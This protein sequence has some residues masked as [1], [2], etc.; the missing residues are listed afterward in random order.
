MR[1]KQYLE[2]SAVEKKEMKEK[3]IQEK[4]KRVSDII[5]NYLDETSQTGSFA[6]IRWTRDNLNPESISSGETYKGGNAIL[7]TQR[8]ISEN[9][10]DNR[11]I[12]H[13]KLS[14]I[15][16]ERQKEEKDKI[17]VKEK[18]EFTTPIKFVSITYTEDY[19]KELLKNEKLAPEQREKYTK[20][21]DTI[22]ER[23]K[24]TGIKPYF[25]NIGY[26]S[27][28]NLSQLNP[29]ILEYF[30]EKK[31]DTNLQMGTEAY[32]NYLIKA[33]KET[34]HVPVVE[35]KLSDETAFRGNKIT[36][37]PQENFVND[38]YYLAT[39]AHEISHS[40]KNE[41]EKENTKNNFKLDNI[42]NYAVEEMKAE[43]SAGITLV[44][45]GINI[46]S[47]DSEKNIF[48]S[49]KGYIQHYAKSIKSHEKL[50]D[51]F[52][53]VAGSALERSDKILERVKEYEKT[54]SFEDFKKDYNYDDEIELLNQ[55]FGEKELEKH[56]DK[57]LH[58]YSLDTI[59]R[60]IDDSLSKVNF[61]FQIEDVDM[62]N[63][64]HIDEVT[65]STADVNNE[66]IQ[67]TEFPTLNEDT[68][69]LE[70][71]KDKIDVE[72]KIYMALSDNSMRKLNATFKA[73]TEMLNKSEAIITVPKED[74]DDYKFKKMEFE[75]RELDFK[76]IDYN[77]EDF[78]NKTN[79][80][81]LEKYKNTF[82]DKLVV[83]AQMTIT[84]NKTLSTAEKE[85]DFLG[86]MVNEPY[87][88]IAFEYSPNELMI[89]KITA[90]LGN[91]IRETQEYENR[92]EYNDEIKLEVSD[93]IFEKKTLLKILEK[94]DNIINHYM[95]DDN[96]NFK[97]PS[98]M[99]EKN[100]SAYY[101]IT[102]E[103]KEL[104]ISEKI[105]VEKEIDNKTEKNK[106]KEIEY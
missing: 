17:T 76:G 25:K 62:N 66:A 84:E 101:K 97:A 87:N 79:D 90:S 18:G 12:S 86:D 96:S 63:I 83:V 46:E 88:K 56:D 48:G 34:S 9:W 98:E 92:K 85:L 19:Y 67:N 54:Y 59:Q 91:I 57:K 52:K 105:S 36:M 31:A 11:F 65:R 81:Y 3:D 20:K 64:S 37:P 1:K 93:E 61:R 50:N 47:Q 75:K 39:L 68:L 6:S 2:K 69:I 73:Y 27:L 53:E 51:L 89:Q 35:L 60:L 104:A 28:Y 38:R 29:E 82:L 10:E 8:I 103:Q 72:E 55:G 33:L 94:E 16:F 80:E 49:N 70:A 100:R 78:L 102:N 4:E 41:D 5:K 15:N 32:T 99:L 95:K 14:S 74:F 24:E 30:P 44:K 7:L 45:L 43:M 58:F 26:H 40:I 13:K 71:K 21:L 22:I 23:E 106:E 77:E 42:Q